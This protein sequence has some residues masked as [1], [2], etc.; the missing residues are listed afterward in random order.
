M[1]DAEGKSKLEIVKHFDADMAKV[2][3]QPVTNLAADVPGVRASADT[4]TK[5]YKLVCVLCAGHMNKHPEH[6]HEGKCKFP[7]VFIMPSNPYRNADTGQVTSS[8]RKMSFA[9]RAPLTKSDRQR[10]QRTILEAMHKR[11]ERNGE[12]P[13]DFKTMLDGYESLTAKRVSEWIT[14]IGPTDEHGGA[15]LIYSHSYSTKNLLHFQAHL[16]DHAIFAE[17]TDVLVAPLVHYGW[18]LTVGYG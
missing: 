17:T 1:K 8:W 16:R 15:C 13:I 11:S 12:T 9:S 2:Q 4:M 5:G 14:Q 18:W 10:F 6:F 3:G 7:V